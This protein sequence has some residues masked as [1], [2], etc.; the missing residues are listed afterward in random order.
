MGYDYPPFAHGFHFRDRTCHPLS[1]LTT[2]P[3]LLVKA[4]AGSQLVPSSEWYDSCPLNRSEYPTVSFFVFRLP[5]LISGHPPHPSS[6]RLAQSTSG[7]FPHLTGQHP[8]PNSCFAGLQRLIFT[9]APSTSSSLYLLSQ[10]HRS[11]HPQA[12]LNHSS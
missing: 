12:N 11:G 8:T 6:S 2:T 1:L 10:T 3:Q 4:C 9:S 7:R 5:S